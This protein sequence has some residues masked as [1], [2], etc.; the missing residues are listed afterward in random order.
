MCRNSNQNPLHN[1]NGASGNLDFRG[2]FFG[3]YRGV[4]LIYDPLG[5]LV[6]ENADPANMASYDF[7]PPGF[8]SHLEKDVTPWLEWGNVQADPTNV[9]MRVEALFTGWS[10]VLGITAEYFM[11]DFYRCSDYAPYIPPRA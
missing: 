3:D 8:P 6:D 2:K 1:L 4:Q 5:K 10:G 7:K 9:Q 11:R